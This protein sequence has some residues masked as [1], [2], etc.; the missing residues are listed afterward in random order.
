MTANVL[1]PA[2]TMTISEGGNWD[3][4]KHRVGDKITSP[5]D[6][7]ITLAGVD[8]NAVDITVLVTG[9]WCGIPKINLPDFADIST[10]SHVP[11]LLGFL[12]RSSV[13]GIDNRGIFDIVD[14]QA[15]TT[16]EIAGVITLTA[17]NVS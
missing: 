11:K 15:T 3:I 12:F 8:S 1:T 2:P 10:T 9:D 6:V 14:E 5:D 16:G 7:T 4:G 13:T 17:T